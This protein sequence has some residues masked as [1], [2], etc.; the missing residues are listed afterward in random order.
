M[1]ELQVCYIRQPNQGV[2]TSVFF[3][4]KEEKCLLVGFSFCSPDDQFDRRLGRLIALN[5]LEKRPIL[6]DKI[7]LASNGKLDV[8]G[9]LLLYVADKVNNRVNVY[10]AFGIREYDGAYTGFFRQWL[11]RLVVLATKHWEDYPK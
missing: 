11:T 2:I 10:S 6:I 3:Y 9:T 5:R 7:L 8:V 1:N 4:K